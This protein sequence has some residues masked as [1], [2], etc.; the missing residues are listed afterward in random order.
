[1]TVVITLRV[2]SPD[3]HGSV[4]SDKPPI[5]ADVTL[6]SKT[7]NIRPFRQRFSS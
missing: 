4:V 6:R 7:P 5:P 3:P 1:M 2:M